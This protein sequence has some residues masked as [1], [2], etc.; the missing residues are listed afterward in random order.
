[1]T[2]F[3]LFTQHDYDITSTRIYYVHLYPFLVIILLN[4]LGTRAFTV[5][6]KRH[7]DKLTSIG[8][9]YLI[10]FY[11]HPHHYTTNIHPENT[12]EEIVYS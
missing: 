6:S 8:N 12:H 4:Y 11:N 5:T 10:G 9:I 3:Y 2:T 7:A 1:M